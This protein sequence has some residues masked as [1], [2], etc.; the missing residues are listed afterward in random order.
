MRL[1]DV[2]SLMNS[3]V[4]NLNGSSQTAT[5]DSDIAERS[6]NA[7]VEQW[8]EDL[9]GAM[10]DTGWNEEALDAF[11]ETSRGYAHRLVTGERP[12]SLARRLSLPKD[13]R[14]RV[15]A[16]EAQREGLVCIEP[17]DP[18]TAD[19]Y[20]RIGL[21][22]MLAQ[23]RSALPAKTSGPVKAELQRRASDRKAVV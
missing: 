19:R 20:L 5:S 7:D 10:G 22:S 17:V 14:K 18:A 23:Q 6:A 8:L 3:K 2:L 12:W 11:W 21:F 4:A 9:R 1:A 15:A 13:L 16:I